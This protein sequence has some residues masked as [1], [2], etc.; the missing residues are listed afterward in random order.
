MLDLPDIARQLVAP[1]KGI[2][3]ADESN[4]SADKR[5]ASYGI[6]TGEEMHR[7]FRDLF[8]STPGIENYLS[9]VILYKETLD[10]KADSGESFPE[11]LRSK[12]II[13][14]IKVDEGL[15]PF[16]QSAK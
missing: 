3:A 9:G 4:A 16:P 13:P 2:L 10:Q 7:K 5:L 11:L 1:G 12:G 6:E 15:E 8:L 14:G